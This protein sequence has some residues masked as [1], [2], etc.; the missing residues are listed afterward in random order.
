MLANKAKA[1]LLLLSGLLAL[2]LLTLAWAMG[3]GSSEA[4]QDAM[5]NCPQPGKWAISVWSGDDG[6][7]TGQALLTCGAGVVDLAYYI[8][9]DTQ[10]WSRYF[11]GRVDISNLLTLDDMQGVITRGAI[12]GPPPAGT[13]TPTP[14]PTLTPAGT[15]T[16]VWATNWGN[17]ELTQSDSSVT[18]TYAHDQGQIEG[19]VQGNKLIGTWSEYPSYAPPDDA[20]EFEFTMSPDGNSFLGR[21][22][23][24]SVG[25]WE[26]W[27]ATRIQ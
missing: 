23:Y 21:W 14:T 11:V 16:G 4:Q 2:G 7:D 19:T 15:W 27:S 1:G 13:P 18:G 12:A 8:D 17:M 10:V 20:G 26:E 9:P 5:Q 22:R 6:I 25:D 24:D 3:T